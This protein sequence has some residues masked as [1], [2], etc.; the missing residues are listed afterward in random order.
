MRIVADV[1]ENIL[2]RKIG[3]MANGL[4]ILLFFVSVAL[5]MRSELKG[6]KQ[7]IRTLGKYKTIKPYR[8]P[9][10]IYYGRAFVLHKL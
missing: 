4:S 1:M 7:V 2:C 10:K 9:Y 8:K 5:I 3:G 6:K